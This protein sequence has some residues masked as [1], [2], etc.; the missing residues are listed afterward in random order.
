M[1]RRRAVRGPHCGGHRDAVLTD[2]G[3]ATTTTTT[4]SEAG[5]DKGS[6]FV[7]AAL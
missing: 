5:N 3:I 1:P 4:V 2:A 6:T 7:R